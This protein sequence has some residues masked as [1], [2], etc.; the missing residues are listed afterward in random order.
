MLLNSSAVRQDEVLI[1]LHR[2]AFRHEME[3]A[4]KL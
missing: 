3:R 1:L 2:S 4:N